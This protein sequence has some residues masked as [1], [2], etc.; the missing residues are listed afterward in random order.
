MSEILEERI[1]H[2]LLIEI[3][4]LTAFARLTGVFDKKLRLGDGGCREGVGLND[5][6]AS[7]KKTAVDVADDIGA[8]QCEDVTIVED[9]LVCIFKAFPAGVLFCEA[10]AAD[11]GAHGSI[12][13]ED[14]L[15]KRSGEFG[16]GV[17]TWHGL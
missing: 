12:E 6:R 10:I 5:V 8:C 13:H 4:V 2:D 7:F 9:V 17:R 14:A 1:I 3:G 11:G 16:G 15:F